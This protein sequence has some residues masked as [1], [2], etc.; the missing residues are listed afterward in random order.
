MLIEHDSTS[1]TLWWRHLCPNLL[2]TNFESLLCFVRPLPPFTQFYFYLTWFFILLSILLSVPLLQPSTLLCFFFLSLILLLFLYFSLSSLHF[3]SHL[4]LLLS[5][6][7]SSFCLL[8][9]FSSLFSPLQVQRYFGEEDGRQVF[10]PADV[11]VFITGCPALTLKS[12][13]EERMKFAHIRFVTLLCFI[14]SCLILTN[15]VRKRRFGVLLLLSSSLS[16]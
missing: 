13:L 8:D 11:E 15:Y 1:Q 6:L 4:S 5:L 9:F 10:R 16:F 14:L 3:V 12:L 2:C 7:F